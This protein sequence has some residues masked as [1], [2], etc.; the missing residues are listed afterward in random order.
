MK[1]SPTPYGARPERGWSI[2]G[3]FGFYYNSFSQTRQDAIRYHIA[4]KGWTWKQCRAV[5]DRCIKS[6]LRAAK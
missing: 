4:A 1:R 6:Q 5:G 2:V 3:K